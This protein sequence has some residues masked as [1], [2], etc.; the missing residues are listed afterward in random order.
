MVKRQSKIGRRFVC[1]AAAVCGLLLIYFLG[2]RLMDGHDPAKLTDRMKTACVGRFLIDLP[3]AADFSYSHTF[4]HGFWLSSFSETA[5]A[6]LARVAAREAEI[7]AEPNELG[8]K[9]MEKVED[10]QINGFTGKIFTFGRSSVRGLEDGK[11]VYYVNVALQAF[12]HSNGTTFAFKTDAYHPQ[13]TG[14]LRKLVDKLRVIP[15]NEIPTAPGFCFGAGMLLDPLTADQ[16]EGVVMFAGFRE[17][18]DLAIAFNTRAGLR[19]TE[20]G[21][22]ARTVKVNAQMPL[23]QKALLKQL[24]IGPR[25][26]NGVEGDEVVERGTEVNFT[27]VYAFH[28]EVGGTEQNVFLPSLHLEMSTGHSV[29]AGGDPVPSAFGET[30]LLDLW[31]KISSSIRVRPTSSPPQARGDPTPAAPQI[32]DLASAGEVCPETGWWRCNDGGNGVGV[33]GGQRQFLRKG[34]RVPQAL[35]LPPQTLWEKIRGL[36]PSYEDNRPTAWTL[37]DRRGKARMSPAVQLASAAPAVGGANVPGAETTGAPAKVGSFV[38]TGIPSP[39]SG[40]WRCEE[41]EAL[42]GTRWFSEGALLPAATFQ[43][44]SQP[45][46][47]RDRTQTIQRRSLWQLVRLAPK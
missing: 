18:P 1:I 19:N 38:R 15:P 39:A 41:S 7:N 12:V 6:F 29:H 30:A 4:I 46:I 33:L 21:R 45:G 35:L 20:P 28:W 10:V 31:D 22:I 11:D 5:E 36:Q 37:I 3:L 14:N 2:A 9:N 24:R 13:H 47:K 26:I 34:E 16:T 42:D 23:W 25:K 40:W 44:T 8:R 32:G 27:N 17:R 43:V